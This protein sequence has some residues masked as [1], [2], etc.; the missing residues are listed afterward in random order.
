MVGHVFLHGFAVLS[1]HNY[2]TIL[3]FLYLARPSQAL[4]QVSIPMC[5]GDLDPGASVAL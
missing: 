2:S 3:P 1:S 5:S 4:A